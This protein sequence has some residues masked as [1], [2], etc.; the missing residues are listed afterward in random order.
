MI[1]SLYVRSGRYVAI[2]VHRGDK[3]KKEASRTEV[4][5]RVFSAVSFLGNSTEGADDSNSII[6]LWVASD[7]ASVLPE[8]KALALSL[9]PNVQHDRVV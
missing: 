8:V 3:L 2:H 4:P 1:S 7:D 6:G 5:V 9:F